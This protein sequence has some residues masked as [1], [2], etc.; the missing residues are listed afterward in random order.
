[1][2]AGVS[3]IL[4]EP[5]MARGTGGS[6]KGVARPNILSSEPPHTACRAGRSAR[7]MWSALLLAPL[8]ITLFAVAGV[9]SAMTE[10]ARV[11]ALETTTDT[12]ISGILGP[13]DISR[14]RRIFALQKNGKWKAADKEIAQ[15][16]DRILMG[17]VLYQRYM[18]PTKYRSKFRELAN[19][20][21][22]YA[23]HPGAYRVYRL[24]RNRKPVRTKAPRPPIRPTGN[25]AAE[26]AAIDSGKYVSPR[27]RSRSQRREVRRLQAHIRSHVRGRRLDGAMKH[28]KSRKYRDLLDDAET[29]IL[30]A[31]IAKGY[32]HLDQDQRTFALASKSAERARPYEP[33]VD[34]YAGLT[35]WRLGKTKAAAK[36]FDALA[37]STTASSREVATGAF[38]AARSSLVERRPEKVADYFMVAAKHPRTFYGQLARRLLGDKRLPAWDAPVLF[39]SDYAKLT[40]NAYVRRAVALSQIS[41]LYWAERELRAAYQDSPK[42]SQKSLLALA[43]RLGL[44]G[45]ALRLAR[46]ILASDGDAYD[47]ALFP[48]PPWEPQGG[49]RI[50]RAVLFALM[51]QESGFN[52]RAKSG[53]GARGLMQLMPRTASFMARDRSLHGRN[54]QKLFAPEFNVHL[55]QKYVVH[56][57]TEH[58]ILDNL[59]MVVAAYNGGPGNVRKWQRK[60][61][62]PDDPLMFVESLPSRENREFVRRVFTNMWIYRDR[63]G[64]PAP[65]LDALAEGR[66]PIYKALDAEQKAARHQEIDD[67]VF[68]D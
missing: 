5:A 30:Y 40:D 29:D 67:H 50:D 24:A 56:L 11:F 47:R 15:L 44:P 2:L 3:L 68:E 48:L 14:Y 51:R 6:A 33:T 23:D 45:A 21:E 10:D 37:S 43:V 25:G 12:V 16:E 7:T 64:Q 60:I 13:D 39:P 4:Y 58:G 62:N 22:K 66:W 59:I 8:L 57:M 63:L 1:M 18:H 20:M 53:R 55:G 27:K 41:R 26:A 61:N 17:H 28:L 54:K 31:R 42:G 52:S 19:W 35:A 9:A 32:F 49:F 38:W 46:A 34:L 65:S 36:H